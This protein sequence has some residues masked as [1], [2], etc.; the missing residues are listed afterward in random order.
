MSVA[1]RALP[2]ELAVEFYVEADGVLQRVH[3]RKQPSGKTSLGWRDTDGYLLFRYKGKTY[4]TH[5]VLFYYY[6]GYY[7]AQVDHIDGDVVN[8]KESNLR[9]AT[10]KENGR[11]RKLA[12]NN[13]SGCT[14]VSYDKKQ[15]K[16]LSQI[17]LNGKSIVLGRFNDL[18]LAIQARKGA[19][20]KLFG[21]WVRK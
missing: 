12:V 19:E 4:K 16:W 10:Y 6:H 17:M 18:D 21:K 20:Q 14:G 5:R 11:N 1:L 7:P 3:Q 8:N 9:A 15:S 2:E 13:S